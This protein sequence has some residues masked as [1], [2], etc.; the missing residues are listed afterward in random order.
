ML[1]KESAVHKK[2]FFIMDDELEIARA[3]LCHIENDLHAKPFGWI[4][5]VFTA[6]SHRGQ[7]LA[8]QLLR[9]IITEAREKDY[10][11][12]LTCTEDLIPFYRSMGFKTVD[13]T[14]VMQMNFPKS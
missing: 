10:K 9:E 12:I 4:E 5:D 6:E 3:S 13:K 1:E 7:G 2:K 8:K 14:V 11:L